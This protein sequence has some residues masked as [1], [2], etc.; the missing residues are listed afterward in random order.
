MFVQKSLTP[1]THA[2]PG[3]IGNLEIGTRY[4]DESVFHRVI[5]FNNPTSRVQ[6]ASI[7]LSVRNG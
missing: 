3:F 7:T 5:E 2:A 6:S 1:E 4:A